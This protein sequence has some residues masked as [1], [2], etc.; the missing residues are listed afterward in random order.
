MKIHHWSQYRSGRIPRF[1]LIPSTTARPPLLQTAFI[2]NAH[3]RVLGSRKKEGEVERPM[4]KEKKMRG[5]K[6]RR[7]TEVQVE[8]QIK[9]KKAEWMQI[10]K[11]TGA[12]GWT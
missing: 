9:E 1:T 11:G 2:P 12:H 10:E 6:V 4:R 8:T 5:K 3:K 7:D